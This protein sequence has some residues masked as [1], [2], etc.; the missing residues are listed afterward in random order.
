MDNVDYRRGNAVNIRAS[1]LLA[2]LSGA[3]YPLQTQTVLASPPVEERA[4]PTLP[5]IAAVE[6]EPGTGPV[7]RY[8]PFLCKQAGHDLCEFYRYHEYGHIA[9]HHYE[10]NDIT[11]QQKEEE[12]DRWAATHAPRRMVLAAWRFFSA[13]GGATPMHG[14]GPTR[15]ARLVDARNSLVALGPGHPSEHTEHEQEPLMFSALAL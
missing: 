2:L 15:A 3:L 8:N 13:G 1:A 4:D 9:L 11:V 7:I 12:A 10:R 6:Y 5:D 14:D